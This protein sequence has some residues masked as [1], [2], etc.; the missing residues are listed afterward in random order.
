MLE[1]NAGMVLG[2]MAIEMQFLQ[3]RKLL[4]SGTGLLHGHL[5]HL[6][7]SHLGLVLGSGCLHG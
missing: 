7:N 3:Q 4:E 5:K 6:V 1:V 2:P